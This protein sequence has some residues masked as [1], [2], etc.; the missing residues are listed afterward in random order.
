MFTGIVQALVPVQS[1]Q[2][3]AEAVRLALTL[4]P[5]AMSLQS[6][7]SVAVNG[8][9]LTVTSVESG[10]ATF[11]VIPQTLTLTNL[12][13]LQ[14]KDQV[15]VERSMTASDE[16][17]GHLLSGHIAGTV[18]VLENKTSAQGVRCWFGCSKQ[19]LKYIFH[20]GFVALDGASL[21]VSSV[22]R[23]QGSFAVDLIPETRARTTL[24]TRQ[25]GDLVNLEVETQT[26]T[27]VET[28]ELMLADPVWL[29]RFR[30]QTAPSKLSFSG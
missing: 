18:R 15:N 17:G 5:M 7:A 10:V 2:K 19:S 13:S 24:G 25:P 9:C 12:G 8:V 11:D 30:Q 21:T 23:E 20:Q 28:I 3:G 29:E 6:G 14:A 22:N 1:V 26:R 16:I 27:I 4:G